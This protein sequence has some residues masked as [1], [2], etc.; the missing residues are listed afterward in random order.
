MNFSYIKIAA[1]F[2]LVM[3]MTSRLV[4][5]DTG[6]VV[7]PNGEDYI[8]TVPRSNITTVFRV[9]NQ[10]SEKQ[11]L[12][13]E[14]EL[15]EGW[16]LLTQNLPFDIEAHAS[17]IK[18]LC[19]HV[20]Q[21]TTTGN[22]EVTYRVKSRKYPSISDYFTVI[23]NVLPMKRLRI[24]VIQAPTS[25][26]SGETYRI[27]M[28]VSNESNVEGDIKLD[29]R[30]LENLPIL[31]DTTVFHLLSGESKNI[32]VEVLT[33]STTNVSFK[34][35]V[36]INA[37]F[38]DDENIGDGTKSIV[39]ILT[40]S[41]SAVDWYHR[42]PV[43]GQFSYIKQ[44]N[45]HGHQSL[46]VDVS[47]RGRLSEGS[48][49]IIEFRFRN[50]DSYMKS[51][52]IYGEHD[53][54]T[55]SYSTDKWSINIGDG[56]YSL[57]SLTEMGRHGRGIYGNIKIKRLVLGAFY[58][59]ARFFWSGGVKE[60]IASFLKYNVNSRDKIGFYYLKKRMYTRNADIFSMEGTFRPFKNTALEL[61]YAGAT[62]NNTYYDSYKMRIS[63]SQSIVHY[64]FHLISADSD[65]PGY[66][67][68]TNFFSAG[69]SVSVLKNLRLRSQ[70][71]WDKQQYD[72]DT[73]NYVAPLSKY[74]Q[75]G[76]E[77][78]LGNKLRLQLDQIKQSREDR[79]TASKFNYDLTSYRLRVLRNIGK[80]NVSGSVEMGE[81]IN[82]FIQKRSKRIRYSI[83]ANYRPSR[84]H[85]FRGYLYYDKGNRYID[86]KD[87]RV[88]VGI[89]IS[90]QI[91]SKTSFFM[92][93]QNYYSPEYYQMNRN[94]FEL[95]LKHNLSHRHAFS[96]RCR[97]TILRNSL[98]QDDMALRIDYK[99]S[100]GVPISRK[101]SIG[102]IRGH[103]YDTVNNQPMQDVIFRIN[104]LT[105]VT[106]QR[107][108]FSFRALRPGTYLLTIDKSR[109]GLNKVVLQQTPM[110]VSIVGG[111]EKYVE[112]A[113]TRGAS[114]SGEVMVYSVVD[115]SSDHFSADKMQDHMDEFYIAGGDKNKT[116]KN[117][118]E[119]SITNGKTK[120]V[121]DHGLAGILV[122]M[123]M[124][125]EI[126]R[127][128]TDKK[129][130]FFFGELRPGHW[131]FKLYEYNLPD[132]HKFEKEAYEFGL[133]PGEE[134][135]LLVK[136]IPVRRRIQI[137]REGETIIQK[138][139]N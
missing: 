127:R 118:K 122:E 58:Q 59:K 57:S 53:L 83:I 12:I 68:N 2:F 21:I 82:K 33:D 131:T 66:Y 125:E 36:K 138:R 35:T 85:Y 18:L 94:L 34:H 98:S 81:T 134:K 47:G 121:P 16:I 5:D 105:A 87:R 70:A 112:F 69:M 119:T 63:G 65:F 75:L 78:L 8:E 100:L 123:K 55:V 31:L 54:Y 115:D 124:G 109:I 108:N 136:V 137:L 13:S 93:F 27:S 44:D 102:S 14:V 15:P 37:K 22:Y 113:I 101:K 95:Q 64:H 99:L 110:Q 52:S 41:G 24:H 139:N 103:V 132:Y 91:F 45:D 106:D 4:S 43:E 88:T 128:V 50:P 42:F 48:R 120:R 129:G 86:E 71:R 61:E 29:V 28:T 56:P 76:L 67:R 104:D 23:V 32:W 20:P 135:E 40:R 84:R 25:V 133:Q 73:T 38:L 116:K 97:K 46:Q 89:N 130:R 3:S 51:L 74:R 111:E 90:S 9:T 49:D 6:V 7:R 96:L 72:I 80:L 11:D 114:V 107:G 19:F 17:D 126:H 1:I 26:I 79:Y 62:S 30:S 117:G 60:E 92:T 77:Y 39:N 10:T